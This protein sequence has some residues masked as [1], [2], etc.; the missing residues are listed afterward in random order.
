MRSFLRTSVLATAACAAAV[1]LYLVF[2]LP[3]SALR[4]DTP[5]ASD[6]VSGAYHIHSNRSDGTGSVDAIAEA[7]AN[8]ALQFVIITDHGDGTTAAEAPSYR[9]GVLVIDALEINTTDGHLVALNLPR[10]TPYPLAG[11]ARDVVDDVHRMG[12]LAIAAHPDS[13]KAEL[14]WRA[15]GVAIDGLEWMNVDSEWRDERPSQLVATAVRAA[16]RPVE[17]I[18]ALFSRPARTLQRWDA[19][20]RLRQTF[21][22]GAVDA[23]ARIPWREDEEPRRGTAFARPTYRTMFTTLAQR[24]ILGA[25]LSGRA[26]DDARR[27][28]DAIGSGRSY[29]VVRGLGWPVS[30]QF[31]ATV[32]R[33]AIAMGGE[34]VLPDA[35]APAIQMRAAVPEA[36]GARVVLLRDG[37]QVAAGQGSVSHSVNAVGAYRVEVVFPAADVPWIVSNA[38]RV[39]A[40]A[41]ATA[42]EP[43]TTG[44][45][46]PAREWITVDPVGL[47][48]Q[49]EKSPTSSATIARATPWTTLRFGLG[50][51]EPAGQYAAMAVAMDGAESFNQIEF[52]AR[53]DRPRRL[54]V[55]IRVRPKDDR[56]RHS[57]YVDETPRLI[58]LRIQDFEPAERP[59]T[60]LRPNAVPL[61]SLLVVIDT[62]NSRPGTAGEVSISDL[63]LG[64]VRSSP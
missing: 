29:S 46:E 40:A 32:G 15:N 7:A 20:L 4:L 18:T 41:T 61:S 17:S 44:A 48:W 60:S 8:A 31:G 57:V 56:W 53:A 45:Q 27:V 5:A 62:V 14:R 39:T 6:V 24:V 16:V 54:S 28:I 1:A 3:P 35:G 23:H 34:V 58:S 10:P 25:P 47:S 30:L 33:E 26:D 22:L 37:R 55:Q 43:A 21:S 49:I 63:R 51:G 59:T 50:G 64:A 19:A 12:G 38:I 52:T 9:H 36:A 2:T 42:P 13:P 11:S